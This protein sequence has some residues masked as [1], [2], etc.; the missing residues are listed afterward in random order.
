M[1]LAAA[2]LGEGV[3]GLE[4]IHNFNGAA[5]NSLGGFPRYNVDR[6]TGLRSRSESDDVREPNR[7]RS[8]EQ[9]FASPPRG[10]TVTY[11]G[12]VQA[13]S[14]ETLRG[15][16]NGLLNAFADTNF[17]KWCTVSP[18]PSR[19]GVSFSYYARSLS[20]DIDDEQL[21]SGRTAVPSPYE[22]RFTASLRQLDSRY[23]GPTVTS[24]TYANGST[25]TVTNTGW[26]P[27]EP[28][29]TL[30]GPIS[31]SGIRI[32]RVGGPDPRFFELA[33]SIAWA[34]I[35]AGKRLTVDFFN[36]IATSPE[37]G[38]DFTSLLQFNSTWW[39][40]QVPGLHSGAQ[41]IQVTGSSG[42]TVAFSPAF[43]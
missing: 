14:L 36:R 35:N 40:D 32:E 43:W 39:D 7:G 6:I 20:C 34:A 2:T 12:R 9:P 4:A 8:G 38:G 10:K 41:S 33:D 30:L 24:G 16:C 23:F 26:A 25:Q 5:L 15:A 18:H 3:L 37:I 31:G 11:E 27:A 17:P 22:R 42:W 21:R 13:L 29:F 19:G 1:T 28:L